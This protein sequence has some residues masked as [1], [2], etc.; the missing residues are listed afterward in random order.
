MIEDIVE[1]FIDVTAESVQPTMSMIESLIMVDGN[2][3][4]DQSNNSDEQIEKLLNLCYKKFGH[5]SQIIL[6]IDKDY[7]N[8]KND[9]HLCLLPDYCYKEKIKNIQNQLEKML[10][11]K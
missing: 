7:F 2:K 1:V 4:Y 8:L 3:D 9:F 6:K 11:Q 5:N 10:N